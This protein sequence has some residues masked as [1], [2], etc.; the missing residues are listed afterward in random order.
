MQEA[1][2]KVGT[3][4]VE[5]LFLVTFGNDVSEQ[6]NLLCVETFAY[7]LYNYKVVAVQAA[8]TAYNASCKFKAYKKS[9]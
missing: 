6:R 4:G 2:C 5:Y 8:V 9:A 3:V 7:V 1:R